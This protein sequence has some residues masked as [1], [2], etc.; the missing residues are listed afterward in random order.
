MHEHVASLSSIDLA[1]DD[2]EFC[3]ESIEDS[4]SG[5]EDIIGGS[6]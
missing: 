4:D 2:A 5:L 1:T 6:L 3:D